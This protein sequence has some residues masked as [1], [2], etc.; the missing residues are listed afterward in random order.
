MSDRRLR[1]FLRTQLDD[2]KNK[3]LYKT[4]RQIQG[5]QGSAIRVA[6]REVINFCANNYLGLA[7]HPAIVEAAM[8]GLRRYGY[9][10]ASVR[11]ICGTQDAHKGLEQAISSFFEKDD[12]ILYSSC[13][14]ANGGLFETI[15][16]EDDT[17]LSD[18][19]NH[20]S[21]IDGVRLCKAKRFRYKNCNTDDLAHG[22][23]ET[24]GCR[25]RLIA[26]DGVF[27]MDG[28]L[29][30]LAQ[31][32][33]LADLYD[34]IV[35][36]DDSHATGILGPG[37]RGTA[38]HSGVLNRIDI[39]TSTLGKTLGGAAGGFT[40][41][42][43]EV[44]D[45]LRQRSRPYLFSNSLPPPIIAA[46]TKALEMI[47]ASTALRDRLHANARKLRSGLEAAGFT[48]KP[49]QHP[50]LPVMLGD[51]ALASKMADSLLEK[52]IYVIGF[53]YPVVPQGQARIRIQLSAAHT[54]EQLDKAIAA[55]TEVGKE[56]G[57]V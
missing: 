22:L 44:V 34:A 33:E 14:D 40:C 30:P 32:C 45:M 9:G 31:I 48:V 19:L 18:E 6:G 29:A 42:G 39:L 36:V 35:M 4:E 41:A 20:A 49:G 37:G 53:S 12:A 26:T 1:N 17:V 7:N 25:F 5:P 28:S 23:K 2:V 21:I 8:D 43:A 38:E 27:S 13:W 51:A 55:F 15:L 56:L 50:I 16:N 52:G 57:V 11:F 54:D 47:A 46:A 10:M 3:G 24:R